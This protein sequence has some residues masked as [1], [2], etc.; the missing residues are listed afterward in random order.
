MFI[1]P[2]S[3][4]NTEAPMERNVSAPKEYY[5]PLEVETLSLWASGL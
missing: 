3:Q 4:N 2:S 1:A 5:A